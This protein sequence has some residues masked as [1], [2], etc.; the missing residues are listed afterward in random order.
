M[1]GVDM[2]RCV[3]LPLGCT[4]CIENHPAQTTLVVK[5]TLLCTPKTRITATVTSSRCDSAI[6][7]RG[8]LRKCGPVVDPHTYQPGFTLACRDPLG[9]RGIDSA[10]KSR[11]LPA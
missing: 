1:V 8:S 4:F 9:L 5:P 6:R 3:E 7:P 10:S 11:N 2:H